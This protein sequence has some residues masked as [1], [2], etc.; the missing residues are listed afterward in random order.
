MIPE[1]LFVNPRAAYRRSMIHFTELGPQMTPER[2][3]KLEEYYHAACA[4]EAKA[5]ASFLDATRGSDTELRSEVESLLLREVRA[6][7]FLEPQPRAE[8]ISGD[9][10]PY[11]IVGRIGAGG[12]GEVYRANDLNLGRDVA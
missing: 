2:W 12:L 4:M 9:I 5:R 8:G 6:E 7:G 1:L 10:G 3:R 11:R